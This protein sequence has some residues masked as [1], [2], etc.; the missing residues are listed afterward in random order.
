MKTVAYLTTDFLDGAPIAPG[1][2]PRDDGAEFALLADACALHG[3]ALR[4]E[5]WRRIGAGIGYD[6]AIIRST[7]GYAAVW[8]DFCAALTTIRTPLFNDAETVMWNIDK[9]Y[10]AELAAHGAPLA[11]TIYLAQAEAAAILSSFDTLATDEIVVK[12]AIGAG[13]WR[14]ARLKR[15]DALPAAD[16]LPPA[17]TIVQPFLPAVA[18]VGEISLVYFDGAFSHACLKRA[19][20]GDYRTQGRHGAREQV[21]APTMAE[22]D[23]AEQVMAAFAATGRAT[24]L[25]TRVDLARDLSDMPVLM[26][27]ELIEPVLYLAFDG[28]QGRRAAGLLAEA[29]ARRLG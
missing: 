10:L 16:L 24:P 3:V 22:R 7:W 11:P 29:L 15:G 1:A 25:Y 17:A 2:L 18:A 23:A 26:E 27:L 21:Y 20:P 4:P 6:A 19:K 8:R 12:P 13:A 9:R 5:P 14:Q 28:A